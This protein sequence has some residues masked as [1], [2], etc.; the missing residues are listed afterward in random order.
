[1]NMLS[2]GN[3]QMRK[4]MI[5]S[6]NQLSTDSYQLPGK[7]FFPGVF[8]FPAAALTF[9]ALFY[10][11]S[12]LGIYPFTQAQ[13]SSFLIIHDEMKENTPRITGKNPAFPLP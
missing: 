6:N 3:R 5:A 9:F 12:K 4:F 13:K 2:E 10:A 11:I 1:M 8:V 7:Q